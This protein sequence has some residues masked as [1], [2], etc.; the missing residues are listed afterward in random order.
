MSAGAHRRIRLTPPSPGAALD[1]LVADDSLVNRR[2]IEV[3]LERLGHHV[4]G[5]ANGREALEAVAGR[6]FDVVLMDIQMPVMDG[7]EAMRQLCATYSEFERPW[8]ITVT[9]N[10]D[11]DNR[12]ACFAAGADD[13]L[14]KP[15]H[16]AALEAAL[17]EAFRRDRGAAAS[18]A[19]RSMI[20]GQRHS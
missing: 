2:L 4:H 12:R 14:A 8:I 20:G 9:A 15:V 16:T 19:G 3:I 18:A 6:P 17:S 10:T 7:L 13:Y 5:V 1:V 11:D